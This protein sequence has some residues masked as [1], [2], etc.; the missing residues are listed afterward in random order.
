MEEKNPQSKALIV[1]FT[2]AIVFFA[3]TVPFRDAFNVFSMT[4][5]NPA[6]VLYPFLGISYGLPAAIGITIA[7]CLADLISQDYGWIAALEG[8]LPTF[9]ATIVP[10]WIW[11]AVT[12]G[13]DHIHRLDSVARVL[14]FALC[15][16]VSAV[17]SG[18]GFGAVAALT[19]K[20]DFFRS[21]MFVL[22]NNFDIGIILGCLLMIVSNQIISR[23]AGSSRVVTPN[24]KIILGAAAAEIVG[25][26]I[27]IAVLFTT[28]TGDAADIWNDVYLYG[29]VLINSILIVSLDVMVVNQESRKSKANA[30]SAATDIDPKE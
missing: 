11:K 26:I 23:N 24:E 28:R 14:K 16:F 15:V 10:Y 17:I 9:F 7:K 13:E 18:V 4:E 30:A 29:L 3:L 2:S 6:A 5:V 27:L 22:L 20:V 25:L 12:K 19:G 1:G 21:A 8:I